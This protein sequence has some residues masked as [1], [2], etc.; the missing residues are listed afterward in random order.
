MYLI[1]KEIHLKLDEM[2]FECYNQHHFFDANIQIQ[3][4]SIDL[5]LDSVFWKSKRN[6]KSFDLRK[7]KLLDLSPRRYYHEII[8]KDGEYIALKPG[9]FILGR[10]YE[11]Y[12]MPFDCAGKLAGKSSFAR[13]GLGVHIN[14]DFANPGWRGHMPLQLVNYSRTT[15]NIYPFIPIC[16]LSLVKLSKQPDRLYGVQELQS[17]YMEDDGGPSYW[18]RDK[19]IKSLQETFHKMDISLNIQENILS[20]LGVK[21]P[22]IIFRF[23]KFAAKLKTDSVSNT[24]W[25]MQKF[26]KVEKNRQRFE[27]FF[28]RGSQV[29]FALLSGNSLRL[30]LADGGITL[31][32]GIFWTLNIISLIVFIYSFIYDR[33]E[34][35]TPE[36][37]DQE[38]NN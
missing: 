6:I 14:C 16:Q 3:P 34:Y 9:E 1:D 11:K 30:F 23:D 21:D 10:V 12:T 32:K 31:G 38:N 33:K 26:T 36:K 20:S 4:C 8:L 28:I 18:W 37:R 27:E 17:K 29:I 2:K 22:D 7:S 25:I 35:F 15:I 13:L 24:D 19:R 5:R